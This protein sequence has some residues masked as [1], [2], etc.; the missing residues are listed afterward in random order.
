MTRTLNLQLFA[1]ETTGTLTAEMKKFYDKDLI[2]MAEPN[3][4]HNQFG[5]K[6]PIPKNEGKTV[7]FR[8]FSSLPKA[9]KAL[10]EGVT[11]DG[12]NLTVTAVEAT[13]SQYG[14]YVKQSDLLELTSVDN[15]ILEATKLLGGQAGRTLDTV[16]RNEIAGCLNVLYANGS[17]RETLTSADKITLDKVFEAAAILK[18]NNAPTIDGSYIGII[19]PYVA[20]DLMMAA[21]TAGTW[22]DV[23]KYSNPEAIYNGE[24][25]KIG[26]VRFVETSEAKYW[27]GA[28]LA[29]DSR[30]LTASAAASASTSV[31]FDGGTV[32]ADALIG[33]YVII[34]TTKAKVIDNTTSSLT[35]DK[36]V[37]CADNAVIY[38]GEGASDGGAVFATV[39]LGADAYGVTEVEGG[40]LETIVKQRGYGDDPLNQRSSVGWKATAVAKRLVE[41]YMVRIESYSSFSLKVTAEN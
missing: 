16:T 39:I 15:T 14:D 26:G 30:T 17:Y 21:K 24:I 38:P 41:E 34:G 36:A 9:T 40:G 5:Q 12:S 19:H 28:D 6:R 3:L 8:K 37:T 10:T 33:R 25:G 23:Q 2:T 18:N 27:Y 13:V 11:P 1:T 32:A 35:L 7:N 29:S 22:V 4:V 31:S 20:Y